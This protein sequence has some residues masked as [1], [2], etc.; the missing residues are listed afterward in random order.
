[1]DAK[2]NSKTH[3]KTKKF[4]GF[5]S[6]FVRVRKQKV[7]ILYYPPKKRFFKIQYGYLNAEFDADLGSVEKGVKNSREKKYLKKRQKNGIF[8]YCVQKF[9]AY[10]FFGNLFAFFSTGSNT[11]SN[12]AFYG[13]NIELLHFLLTLTP[14]TDETAHKNEKRIL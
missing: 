2:F 12:F 6:R 1:M 13:T 8:F 7:Q 10:T 4:F 3:Y 5:L 11:V 14:N 9:L